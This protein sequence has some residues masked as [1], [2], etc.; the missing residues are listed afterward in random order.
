M[1]SNK[2]RLSQTPATGLF[3]FAPRRLGK[4][5]NQHAS[6]IMLPTNADHGTEAYVYCLHEKEMLA[7]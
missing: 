3:T 4:H 7:L 2:T 6:L 1:D 5:L